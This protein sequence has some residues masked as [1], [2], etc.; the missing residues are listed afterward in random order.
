METRDVALKVDGLK[1]AGMLHLPAPMPSPCPTVCLCHGIPARPPDPTDRGY[2]ILAERICAEGFAVLF[3]NFRGCGASEGSLDMPGWT[4]DLAAIVDYLSMTPGLDSSRLTLFGF[5]GGAA[6]AVCVAAEDKRVSS[7]AACAC[8][9]EFNF[10]PGGDASPVIAHF[11]AIGSIRDPHFPPS[12]QEWLASFAQVRP[13][14]CVAGIAPRPL[15]L[16]HGSDDET[17]NVSH[18]RRLY[19]KAGEPKELAIIE[20]AGHRLRLDERAMATAIDWLKNTAK[21]VRQTH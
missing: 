21:S 19:E 4:R 18:A 20:G 8:P 6:V 15:L 3:F 17:V 9:A 5:S 12:P 10:M 16:V 14:E 13:V 7:V 11:R 2:A 1:I